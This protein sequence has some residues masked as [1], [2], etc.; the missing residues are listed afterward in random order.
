LVSWSEFPWKVDYLTSKFR[1]VLKLVS[2]HL[3]GNGA[4]EL[5]TRLETL[6]KG[7]TKAANSVAKTPTFGEFQKKNVT[8]DNLKKAFITDQ[9]EKADAEVKTV[10]TEW[11]AKLKAMV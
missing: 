9:L 7:L 5:S 3:Q 4:A 11:Q 1:K 8:P 6:H 2:K 10:W